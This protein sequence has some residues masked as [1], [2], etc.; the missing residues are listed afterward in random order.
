MVHALSTIPTAVLLPKVNSLQHIESIL[1][2]HRAQGL[3]TP[4]ITKSNDKNCSTSNSNSKPLSKDDSFIFPPLWAMIETAQGVIN[5]EAIASSTSVTALVF[6][7]NDL[8]KEL[9]AKHTPSRE[10][11]LYAMSKT[12]NAARAYNKYV[13]DGVHL[14]IQDDDGL[15]ASCIQGRNLGFDGKSLIHPNQ[16]E[17]TNNYFS[18]SESEILL[19]ERIVAAYTEAISQGKGV[20][21]VDGKMVEYLHVCNAQYIL[22]TTKLI[23]NNK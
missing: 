8:T 14:D 20:C 17:I 3:L 7:S 9:K 22:D 16:V 23:R 1:R 21:T 13:I 2:Q 18:P 10:P 19:A 11:L 15:I 6:G 5:A 4:I 12:I